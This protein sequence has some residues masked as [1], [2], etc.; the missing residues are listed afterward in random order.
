[1][2]TIA[3]ADAKKDFKENV[4]KVSPLPRI[5]NRDEMPW[6]DKKEFETTSWIDKYIKGGGPKAALKKFRED[7]E[8]EIKAELDEKD[9][10]PAKYEKELRKRMRDEVPTKSKDMTYKEVMELIKEGEDGKSVRRKRKVTKEER[11]DRKEEL[12]NEGYEDDEIYEIMK[13]EF[14]SR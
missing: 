12:K 3:T 13:D 9:L 2:N 11:D 10:T 4:F 14:S 6:Y 7:K 5:L 1:M 8:K